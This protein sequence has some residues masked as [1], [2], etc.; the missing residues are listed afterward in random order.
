[1]IFFAY[2][3][4][5]IPAMIETSHPLPMQGSTSSASEIVGQLEHELHDALIGQL[6]KPDD[7]GVVRCLAGV[8]VIAS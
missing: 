7:I 2:S 4:R 6:G 8:R 5:H 3:R 1:V